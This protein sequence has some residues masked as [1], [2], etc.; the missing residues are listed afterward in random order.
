MATAKILLAALVLALVMSLSALPSSH[1]V[2]AAPDEVNKW[3]QVK[4]PIGGEADN[5]VLASGSDV[6]QLTMAPD[7]T[8]YAYVVSASGTSSTLFKSQDEGQSWS[9]TG[10]VK[11]AIV[12]IATAPD[13]AKIIYYATISQ[14]YKSVDA[15]N[16]FTLFPPKPGGAGS[17][18]ITITSITIT[19]NDNTYLVAV[20]TRDTDSS[21]YG[22]VYILDESQ[23]LWGWSSTNISNYD[24]LRVAFSPNFA[25]DGQL[26]AV[27]TNEIDTMVTIKVGDADWG[28]NF[29]DAT[30]HSVVSQ[31]ASIAFPANYGA[32]RDTFTLFV[33]INSSSN[34]GDAYI[35]YSR[36]MPESSIVADL[37]I[38]FN[39]GYNQLGVAWL[40][41]S[42]NTT[43]ATLL[44]GAAGSAQ[45]YVSTDSGVN[46]TRSRKAPSGQSR[47]EVL[48]APDFTSSR[49]AYVATSGTE[50][51]LSLT[52]DGGI[53]WNQVSLI[54]TTLSAIVGLAPSPNYA[55]DNT[56]FLLT[57]DSGHI[58]HSLWRSRN[59]GVKWDRVLT[60]STASADSINSVQLPR[61]YG[62][63][64][65]VVF[66]AG[67]KGSNSV[68]WKSSDNG[69]TFTRR[70]APFL[71]D[72]WTV[73][74]D[75]SLFVGGYDGGH[76]LVYSTTN[77]GF[78]YATGV[79]AGSQALQSIAISPNY[80]HDKTILIGNTSGWVYWSSDNGTSFRPLPPDTTS[81]PLIGLIS[82]TFDPD[83]SRN[84]TV[85]A[86][87]NNASNGIY[88]Y[89][90]NKST[91]WVRI[92]GTLP[93]GGIVSQ[94]RVATDG[95]LY[96]A[97]SKAN[98]GMERSLAPTYPLGVTF[99]TVTGGLDD[100]V[101]L[102]GLWLSGNQ[103]WSVD[104]HNTRLMTYTDSLTSP[105]TLTAPS[106]T[107]PGIATGN[108][109]LDWKS[110]RGATQY[111]W[112]LDYD[113][114]F[115]TVPSG[116]EGNTEGSSARLP[117]LETAT[118]Y[119]WRV[120]ATKPVLS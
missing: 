114:D 33:G 36:A 77:G 25:R 91:S 90:I 69:Q 112:Q 37:N 51:A 55:Q 107:A 57:F 12:A 96:A 41:V 119:Y 72:I 40:A 117:A 56:L 19:R 10:K 71:F 76:G 5:W 62:N 4:M 84:N 67:T 24:V 106:N 73:A 88:R 82:V 46:W 18:N 64:H 47:T 78:S 16:T 32:T 17:N 31:S 118:T 11:D 34:N 86:A 74:N 42:G 3:S 93:V 99:E 80:E 85:Y 8:L 81:S 89:I 60:S 54:D 58:E 44:A 20:G 109:I 101:T 53:S 103:M 26:V 7:G 83:F 110:L 39:Y 115:S 66:L 70:D 68:I 87:S 75:D 52:A 23:P 6:R 98:G 14:L 13:D 15:G 49:R 108:I 120:R 48:M 22:G 50:S 92:D 59:S 9:D 111:Q 27:V 61:Q 45:I 30:I 105:V 97:N 104:S 35:I 29:S 28:Q 79:V 1:P 116:F 2:V 38:G 95:T 21:Q 63:G 113:T 43:G 100:G 94:I 65:Q 102:S